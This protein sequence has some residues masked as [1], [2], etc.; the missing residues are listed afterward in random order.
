MLTIETHCHT[1]ASK[2]S[3]V[4]PADLVAACRRRGLDRVII[5][6]HNSISGA[7]EAQQ[8]DPEL[9]IVGEEV[10]TD[11]GELLAAYVTE[12]VPKRTPYRQAI[13]QLR[14]QGAFISVSHPCD[15]HRGLWSHQDLE[16]L[17]ELVDAFETFN[18]RN[19]R[20]AYN[21]AAADLAARHGLPGT[22]GSDAHTLIELGRATMRLPYFEDGESLRRAV[23]QAELQGRPSGAWVRLASRWAAWFG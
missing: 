16:E 22:A 8:L 23:N 17:A 1:Y 13:A 6:D 3:K 10:L 7:L 18:A 11:K 21:Q 9:V 5:T 2:D 12:L 15:P 4:K 14:E 19:L 20:P